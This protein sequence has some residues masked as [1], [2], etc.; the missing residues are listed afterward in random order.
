MEII[1]QEVRFDL[2]CKTCDN[3]DVPEEK[4]PCYEC[5]KHISNVNSCKPVMYK[6]TKS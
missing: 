6:N 4:D 2:Y 1:E 3:K 5:L